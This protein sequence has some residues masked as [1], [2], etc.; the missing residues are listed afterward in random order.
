MT[1]EAP[2]S[3]E[4]LLPSNYVFHNARGL[5]VPPK[6]EGMIFPAESDGYV[7]PNERSYPVFINV[8]ASRITIFNE[9]TDSF[10]DCFQPDQ[11]IGD[12]N[13]VSAIFTGVELHQRGYRMV[14]GA[15]IDQ[16]DDSR[17]VAEI[18]NMDF[19]CSNQL[20]VNYMQGGAKVAPYLLF[21]TP[22]KKP[23]YGAG[24]G[25]WMSD[26]QINKLTM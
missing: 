9:Y 26:E 18:L 25:L 6:P 23:F 15:L 8:D 12:I 24:V 11:V 4:Q 16:N 19:D 2:K 13:V 14:M 17:T 20:I 10:T 5:F 7:F 3:T 21:N 1:F 22:D